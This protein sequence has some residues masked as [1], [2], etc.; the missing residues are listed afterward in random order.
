MTLN[1]APPNTQGHPGPGNGL[2]STHV[3]VEEIIEDVPILALP[4]EVGRDDLEGAG[5]VEAQ[6]TGGDEQ[7]QRH[8]DGQVDGEGK[9]E[10]LD[11]DLTRKLA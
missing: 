11:A 10:P 4:E 8:R 5:V 9:A 6:A 2:F 3:V 7:G 1:F